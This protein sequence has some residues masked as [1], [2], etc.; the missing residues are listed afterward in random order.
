MSKPIMTVYKSTCVFTDAEHPNGYSPTALCES[1]GD[2]RD[3]RYAVVER[4]SKQII[5]LYAELLDGLNAQK[6]ME[7]R[8]GGHFNSNYAFTKVEE[9][10]WEHWYWRSHWRL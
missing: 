5:G 6:G 3:P 1:Y 2:E 7:A 4:A 8:S 10:L 9:V